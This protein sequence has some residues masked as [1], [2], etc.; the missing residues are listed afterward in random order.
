MAKSCP[1][2]SASY[3]DTTVFCPVDGAVLRAEAA[4]HSLLG[5]IIA[6]RYLVTS[7][8]GE[9]GMGMVYRAQHVKLPREAAIKVMHASLVRDP[10]SLARFNREASAASKVEHESVARVFDFGETPDGL[11]YLAME[12]LDGR[13]LKQLLEDEGPLP[14]GRAAALV[15]QIAAG[16]EAAHRQGIVHRD[17]KPDNVLVVKDAKGREQAK[18]VDFG[19]AKAIGAGE[20]AL[21]RTGF[22]VGTPEYMSPE[23]LLGED[24]DQRS[25]VYALA[26]LTYQLLTGD[27]PFDS[28]TPDRGLMARLT[29]TPR[30]LSVVRPEGRWSDAVQTVLDRALHRDRDQRTRS[31]MDFALAFDVAITAKPSRPKPVTPPAPVIPARRPTPANPTPVK[32]A[33]APPVPAPVALPTPPQAA[34]P[35]VTPAQGRMPTPFPPPARPQVTSGGGGRRRWLP[36]LPHIPVARWSVAAFVIWFGYLVITTGSVNRAVREV[37]STVLQLINQ[38]R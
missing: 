27:M 24:V 7:L 31:A 30:P 9:G 25:D 19:I 18:I 35:Y 26:L 36:H 21:T 34:A 16:L 37:R 14:L 29:S 32:P 2:C 6:E 28:R 5:T 17:L 22:V 33:P 10:A 15:H 4:E 23:Q 1:T 12:Y 3:P 20:R 38:V 13:T 11:V 8:I